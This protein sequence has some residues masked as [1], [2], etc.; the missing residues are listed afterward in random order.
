M[1]LG[2]L[3]ARSGEIRDAYVKARQEERTQELEFENSRR[4]AVTLQQQ[5][6]SRREILADL[7]AR[8]TE[9]RDV[10][11]SAQAQAMVAKRCKRDAGTN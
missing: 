3:Q 8:E 4:E 6:T 11:S 2:A 1:E 10:L 7:A 9:A 5:I